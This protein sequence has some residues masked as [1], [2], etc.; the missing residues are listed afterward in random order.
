MESLLHLRCGLAWFDVIKVCGLGF[1]VV[2][3][4]SQILQHVIQIICWNPN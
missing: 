3:Q 4:V 2:V 1:G